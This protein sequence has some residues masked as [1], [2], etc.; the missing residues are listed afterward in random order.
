MNQKILITPTSLCSNPKLIESL[1]EYAELDFK[2]R[3]I[4][5]DLSKYT[6]IILG[7][8]KLREKELDR[9]EN[10]ELIARYGIG[11]DEINTNYAKQKGIVVKNTPGVASNSI[12][13]YTMAAIYHV[14]KK[15]NAIDKKTSTNL[16][17]FIFDDIEGKTLGIIGMGDIGKEI[18]KKA[19]GNDMQINAYNRT[20]YKEF[21]K[22]HDIKPTNLNEL[23]STSDFISINI[24]L[25]KQTKYL[26][27]ETN[28]H[29][30]KK[31]AYVINTARADIIQPEP[32]YNAL[33]QNK[34]AGAILD[35]Y[36][37][38][39]CFETLTNTILTPH[40]SSR[41]QRTTNKKIQMI[42]NIIKEH[43]ENR[44]NTKKYQ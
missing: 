12:A 25:T 32:F 8:E 4:P 20:Q 16:N 15:M 14:T 18:A 30:I 28:I 9:A 1:K 40:I 31:T 19:K 7:N 34:I 5:E 21:Y 44:K 17:S 35:V 29:L 11:M 37:E 10:L 13:E 26:L 39:Q 6:I 42:Q 24:E 43:I 36:Q 2:P 3:Q 33:K 27:N 23:L 22:N 41:S 38:N